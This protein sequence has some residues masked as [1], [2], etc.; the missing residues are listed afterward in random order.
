MGKV[1]Q[2]ILKTLGGTG[3]CSV[4]LLSDKYCRSCGVRFDKPRGEMLYHSVARAVR[5]LEDKGYV[6]TKKIALKKLNPSIKG[7]H[8][9]NNYINPTYVKLVWR[10][11]EP[12]F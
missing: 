3:S 11:V 4:T 1:E 7:R 10:V 9:F 8:M 12:E 6:K 5:S 2:F